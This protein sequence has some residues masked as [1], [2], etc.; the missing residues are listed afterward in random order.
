[1]LISYDDAFRSLIR[2]IV[3]E[4][5]LYVPFINI[6]LIGSEYGQATFCDKACNRPCDRML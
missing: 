6:A 3:A 5:R 2:T 1:M 4:K